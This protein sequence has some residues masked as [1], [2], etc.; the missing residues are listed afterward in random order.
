MVMNVDDNPQYFMLIPSTGFSLDKLEKDLLLQALEN[1]QHNKTR[2]AQMLG[3]TRS[4][5]RS[6][7]R[8]YNIE[9]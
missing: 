7:L 3:I 9:C 2:A 6:M 8:K 4:R 5:F 1:S